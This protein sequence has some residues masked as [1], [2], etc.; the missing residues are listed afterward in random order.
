MLGRNAV[1]VAP[2]RTNVHFVAPN[3]IAVYV[4]INV[5]TDTVIR[6]QVYSFEVFVQNEW[7]KYRIGL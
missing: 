3:N 1:N 7:L 5:P 4:R 6:I 2:V